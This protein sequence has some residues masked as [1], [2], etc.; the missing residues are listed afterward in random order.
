MNVNSYFQDGQW[1]YRVL[2][3]GLRNVDRFSSSLKGV[4][5]EDLYYK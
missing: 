2:A 4:N 1:I 3:Y 5:S